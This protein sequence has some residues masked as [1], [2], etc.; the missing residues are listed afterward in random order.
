MNTII[1]T[2]FDED[3]KEIIFAR[4]LYATKYI[5]IKF[6]MGTY[7]KVDSFLSIIK[8]E[9]M[10]KDTS[11][12]KISEIIKSLGYK[13]PPIGYPQ[14][15]NTPFKINMVVVSKDDMFQYK[16]RLNI[17]IDDCV[18][19]C[20]HDCMNGNL[21]ISSMYPT[22]KLYWTYSRG[23][24]KTLANK[25]LNEH[26][27]NKFSFSFDKKEE[28]NMIRPLPNPKRVICSGPVTTVIYNDGAKTHVRKMEDDQNDYEKAFLLSWLYKTYGKKAVNK[29][30]DEF[31]EEFNKDAD[32]ANSKE[33]AL[34]EFSAEKVSERLSSPLIK[35]I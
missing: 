30:L 18:K 17:D 24:G 9:Y 11:I 15:G 16:V 6:K 31:R 28:E 19:Y 20:M 14:F 26:S 22:R 7:K 2:L 34:F 27:F 35:G 10:N 5:E 4:H 12:D 25:F 21:D 3:M 33:D 23:A 32:N 13:V 8:N 29:K 1:I